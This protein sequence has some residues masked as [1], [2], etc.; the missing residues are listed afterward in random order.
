VAEL[1]INAVLPRHLAEDIDQIPRGPVRETQP[2][3]GC[4]IIRVRLEVGLATADQVA[5]VPTG[6]ELDRLTTQP[7]A[8]STGGDGVSLDGLGFRRGNRTR[9]AIVERESHRE[10]SA[11][12]HFGWLPSIWSASHHRRFAS[13]VMPVFIALVLV[14]FWLIYMSY[15]IQP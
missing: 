1:P 3:G 6:V 11:G 14:Y 10:A 9:R 2:G 8:S 4:G 5:V 12:R 15:Y 13:L 7:G